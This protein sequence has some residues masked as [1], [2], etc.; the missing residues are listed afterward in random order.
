MA[1]MLDFSQVKPAAKMSRSVCRRKDLC[2]MSCCRLIYRGGR[3][4][5]CSRPCVDHGT[6]CRQCTTTLKIDRRGKVLRK[7]TECQRRPRTLFDDCDEY[8]K[9]DDDDDGDE[10]TVI[11]Q[12]RW[13]PSCDAW[14]CMCVHMTSKRR[15]G[16][17]CV[18]RSI[19]I[20]DLCQLSTEDC[21]CLRLS[22]RKQLYETRKVLKQVTDALQRKNE[23]LV[24]ARNKIKNLKK[25]GKFT[26]PMTDQ[27]IKILDILK[28]PK[29]KNEFSEDDEPLANIRSR[30]RQTKR[31][32]RLKSEF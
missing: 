6:Y 11:E 30:S 18:E 21:T 1:L 4:V 13:C 12:P 7:K 5:K 8:N 15:M 14:P 20:C 31:E 3:Y 16:R 28:E 26:T 25:N 22:P 29:V 2:P 17:G 27:L 10:I 24:R 9:T 19:I 23:K 32:R